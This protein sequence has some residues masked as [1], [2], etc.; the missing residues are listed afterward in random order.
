MDVMDSMDAPLRAG[1]PRSCCS[2]CIRG[3][4]ACL[5]RV[6]A[7]RWGL[8]WTEALTLVSDVRGLHCVIFRLLCVCMC[9]HFH[10][11][12][13]CERPA[14]ACPCVQV[15]HVA[16]LVYS[17]MFAASR[18]AFGSGCDTS[19]SCS[20]DVTPCWRIFGDSDVRTKLCTDVCDYAPVAAVRPFQVTSA[21]ARTRAHTHAHTHTH[22]HTPTLLHT[23]THTHIQTHIIQLV[24]VPIGCIPRHARR[25]NRLLHV[26]DSVH[27]AA[28]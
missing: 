26:G 6:L 16:L 12:S 1:P 14:R 25:G 15:A 28:H 13:G 4:C 23:N 18:P 27:G 24:L 17:A 20:A 11:V 2:A 5:R 21:H 7:T 9:V 3:T 22:T 8:L 19:D 10:C